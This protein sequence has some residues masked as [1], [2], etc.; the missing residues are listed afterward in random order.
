MLLFFTGSTAQEITSAYVDSVVNVALSKK[1]SDKNFEL[2]ELGRKIQGLNPPEALTYFEQIERLT[3][4]DPEALLTSYLFFGPNLSNNGMV[5]RSKK[6]RRKG[7]RL[8]KKINNIDFQY[9]FNQSLSSLYINLSVPDS[10][11]FYANEA[12]KIAL[13]Y[14]KEFGHLRWQIFQ[15][16]ADIQNILGNYEAQAA[17]Y[18]KAW[19]SMSKYPENKNKG[20]L[21]YVLTDFFREQKNFEKQT[22]YTGLLV[23]YYN[24]KKVNT[25]DYHFPIESVLLSENSP[26]AIR[27]LKRVITLSDSLNNYNALS[28][29]TLTLAKALIKNNKGAEALPYL[30]HT[31]DKLENVKYNLQNSQGY[32]LLQQAYVN[33]GDYKNAYK[34]LTHQKTIEDSLRSE[35][36]ISKI[37][38][39][40]VKYDTER[41]ERELEKQQ[42]SKKILYILLA[43]GTA[44]LLLISFFLLKNRKKNRLLAKQK[45]MLEITIDEKNTLLKETHHRVKN[46]FQIVSSLLYLQSENMHDKEAQ[47]A[48]REAQNRVRSMVLIHQK[49]YNKDQLVGINTKEYF[50]DLTKDIFESHQFSDKKISYSLDVAP[51]ILDIETITP[52]GLILN[53]LITNVLKHAFNEVDEKSKMNIQFNRRGE[54]LHLLVQ[55]NGQGMTSDIKES[56]FGIKLMKALAKKL[57]ATLQIE[58]PS[59]EGTLATLHIKRFTLMS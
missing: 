4:N 40:E 59:H 56:S 32:E 53:E 43:S 15:R 50:E 38:D 25:P 5:E 26:E 8:A 18:E 2:H 24:E 35:N 46:S 21:L 58:S 7:L 22:Y 44:L 12:D 19:Q 31:I 30:K 33:A 42:A 55:D 54:E 48:I 9:D 16:K 52:I 57:K 10:A 14:P 45:E 49:L 28:A 3:K 39:Y 51:M 41:K 37:A 6:I 36:M 34:V 13:E 29:S 20:F 23:E 47:L 17:L 11:T 27:D 1:N